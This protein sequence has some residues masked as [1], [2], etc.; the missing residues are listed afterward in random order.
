M[1]TLVLVGTTKGLFTLRSEDGRQQFELTGP[2]FAGE[3]VY[4]TCV[5]TR[6]AAPRIFIGSVSNHWGPV[7]R[8]S[9]N[10]GA[11]WTED[12]R[13]ALA[14]RQDRSVGEKRILAA[15]PD[16]PTSPTSSMP[17]WSPRRCSAA[18]M[19]AVPSR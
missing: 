12:D 4:A 18:T 2:S 19:A 9:D 6:G 3:E 1:D 15:R 16:R 14:F 10:L 11:S 5:D 8:R 17:A 7:L 13:A